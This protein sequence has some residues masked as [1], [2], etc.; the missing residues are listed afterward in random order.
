MERKLTVSSLY[1]GQKS[2]Y[3]SNFFPF[4]RLSGRWLERAGFS[5]GQTVSVLVE[6]GKLTITPVVETKDLESNRVEASPQ[7]ERRREHVTA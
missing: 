7:R 6:S 1:V 2:E 3:E 4:I 5:L